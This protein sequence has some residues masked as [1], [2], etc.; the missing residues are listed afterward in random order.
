MNK[1]QLIGNITHDLQLRHFK[2]GTPYLPFRVATN[3]SYTKQDGEKVDEAEYHR[4][5]AFGKASE[6]IIEFASKGKRIFIDGRL[7]TRT[8]IKEEEEKP[9]YITEIVVERFE[10]FGISRSDSKIDKK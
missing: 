3:R 10:V 9:I 6:L 8:I 4:C 2:D 1:V 5:C 7:K